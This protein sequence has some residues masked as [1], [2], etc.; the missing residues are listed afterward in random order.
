M[1]HHRRAL[2]LF[3]PPETVARDDPWSSV[4]SRTAH[5]D[6]TSLMTGPFASG[7]EV[8]RTYLT[9]HEDAAHEVMQTA[10]WTWLGDPVQIEGQDEFMCSVG[11]DGRNGNF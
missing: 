11:Y 7:Q 2:L 4:P 5:T 3:A 6:H 10:H 9:C 1:Y 8:T